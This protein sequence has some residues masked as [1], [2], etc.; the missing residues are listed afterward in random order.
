VDPSN[1]NPRKS[2]P[3]LILVELLKTKHKEKILRAKKKNLE[4]KTWD[5]SRFLIQ[6]HGGWRKWHMVFR[7]LEKKDCQS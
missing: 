2:M 3:R 5:D 1:I 7:A 6:N 4:G